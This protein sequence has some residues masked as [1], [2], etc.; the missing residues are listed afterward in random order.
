MVI[1]DDINPKFGLP[2]FINWPIVPLPT[3]L[4]FGL[5]KVGIFLV[6]VVGRVDFHNYGC[7]LF[8]YVCY[9]IYCIFKQQILALY[10]NPYKSV[11]TTSKI[12]SVTIICLLQEQK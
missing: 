9:P 1:S 2:S 7:T 10:L 8:Y 3:Y 5:L 6:I 4:V 11:Q 12:L